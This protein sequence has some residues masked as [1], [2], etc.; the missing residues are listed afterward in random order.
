MNELNLIQMLMVSE[1]TSSHINPAIKP[2]FA[3]AAKFGT[4]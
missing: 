4:I 3:I 1:T 2:A